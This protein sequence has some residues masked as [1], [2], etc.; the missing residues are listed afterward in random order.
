MT[1][2]QIHSKTLSRLKDKGPALC[3]EYQSITGDSDPAYFAPFLRGKF[4]RNEVSAEI[5]QLASLEW[6]LHN[7]AAFDEQIKPPA[8]ASQNPRLNPTL[9]VLKL[10]FDAE[11]LLNSNDSPQKKPTL[12]AVFRHPEEQTCKM[13]SL[14]Y[15]DAEALD[16]YEEAPASVETLAP[17]VFAQLK[18]AGI[19]I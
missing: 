4:L 5:P 15:A 10:D 3:E 12:L 1:L 6:A 11:T 16:L 9:N 17:D 7:V 2:R 14:S 13:R 18:Q 8:N 19:F